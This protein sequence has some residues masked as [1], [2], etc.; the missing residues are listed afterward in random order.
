MREFGQ[1]NFISVFYFCWA[2]LLMAP[3]ESFAIAPIESFAASSAAG[4]I[5]LLATAGNPR[6]YQLDTSPELDDEYEEKIRIAYST[7]E[8]ER[9][10][11]FENEREPSEMDDEVFDPLESMPEDDPNGN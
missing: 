6:I 1:N 11:T 7:Y 8:N 9:E 5:T 4:A 10:D 2:G 3:I